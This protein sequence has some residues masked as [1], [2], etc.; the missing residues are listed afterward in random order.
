MRN[1]TIR[2]AVLGAIALAL[3]GVAAV[4]AS[5][6]DDQTSRNTVLIAR[7]T[8][9]AEVDGTGTPN[10]GDPDGEGIASV[11]LDV[12]TNAQAAGSDVCVRLVVDGLDDVV[13]AH[14]H[15]GAAGT[16][17]PV[18]VP[19]PPPTTGASGGCVAVDP[20]L[21]RAIANNPA[22]YYVNVHTAAFPGG[23]VRGQLVAGPAPLT[24]RLSGASELDASGV[25][26]K[27]DPD[28]VGQAVVL[29][30]PEG[31]VCAALQV[32]GIEAPTAGHIHAAGLRANGP[33]VVP[34]E[35]LPVNGASAGCVAAEPAVAGPIAAIPADHY[36]NLHNATYP[37]GAVRG[38]L[39]PGFTSA[40]LVH[41]TGEVTHLLSANNAGSAGGLPLAAPVVDAD[42]TPTARGYWLAASDGGVFAF[43][44]AAF[45]GSAG[46]L[47]LNAPVVGVAGTPTGNGYWLAASDGGVFSYGDAR[48]SGS[49]GSLPLRSPVVGLASTPTGR[50]YWLVAADGG[51]F[52]YGDAAF[53]GSAASI[54][55]T[56]PIVG[57]A[58]TPT[59]LGYW[60]LG[61]DG[62]VFSYGDA[63]YHGRSSNGNDPASMVDIAALPV[64]SGYRIAGRTGDPV[65]FGESPSLGRPTGGAQAQSW[66]TAI[67]G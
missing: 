47:R 60:L 48:F 22:G 56:A 19:L 14:I 46:G 15:V 17:G 64:G 45:A 65:A 34:F 36:V 27:G 16:N 39:A 29:V 63:V 32:R 3:T 12:G 7:L 44:D 13:M 38:Q 6:Q 52:S 58:A 37:G 18:V 62:G 43:G 49:A 8:G 59:G 66:V 31:M 42:T 11:V 20:T 30:D 5:A 61:A 9:A 10:Q 25:G 35:K 24:A 21:L 4:P 28:G 2:R 55:L 67:T 54:R 57:M 23:A 26:F 40:R 41:S 53:F 51:V 1:G 33:V 50:G